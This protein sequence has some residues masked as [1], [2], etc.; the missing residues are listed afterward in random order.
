MDFKFIDP[1]VHLRDF[2]ESAKETVKHG[3]EV[4]RDTGIDAVFDMLNTSPPGIT[5]E[6]IDERFKLA[7]EADIP[8]VTYGVYMVLTKD[9]EQVKKAVDVYNRRNLHVTSPGL[10]GFKMYAGHS[11]NNLGVIEVQDEYNVY[12]TLAREGYEGV[13][14]VHPEKQHFIKDREWNPMI[15]VSHS[16]VV[17]PEASE[18]ESVK[19]QIALAYTTGFKGTL[20]ITHISSP[21]SV[22]LVKGARKQKMKITS[23]ITP[24]HLLYDW[25]LMQQENGVLWKMNPPLR[26]P[27]SQHSMLEYLRKGHIDWIETDHA[28]HTDKDKLEAYASGIVGMPWLPWVQAYLHEVGFSNPQIRQVMYENVQKTFGFEIPHH[29]RPFKD[30][31]ADY[32]HNPHRQLEL[33]VDMWNN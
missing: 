20:H 33:I 1:H 23:G 4:A 30:R 13:L 17:R 26:K 21:M 6:V 29:P 14:A 9:S 27:E 22:E 7:R 16:C 32:W 8:E 24:H 28:P 15:P 18:I 31:R 19:D 5:E 3:L 11:T 10:V 25:T 2:N 12:A